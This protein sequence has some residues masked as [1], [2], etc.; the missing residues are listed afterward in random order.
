M[1]SNFPLYPAFFV[2]NEQQKEKAGQSCPAKDMG[3]SR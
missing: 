1:D 2:L 3:L